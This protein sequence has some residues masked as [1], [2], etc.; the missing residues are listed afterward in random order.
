MKYTIE[1]S[2]EEVVALN[3]L[4]GIV[5]GCPESSIRKYTNSLYDKSKKFLKRNYRARHFVKLLVR[6]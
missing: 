4:T 5:S 3:M 2:K 1:L 6:T